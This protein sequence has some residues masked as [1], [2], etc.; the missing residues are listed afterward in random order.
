M[1]LNRIIKYPAGFCRRG[2]IEFD[3][4]ANHWSFGKIKAP[5]GYLIS[6]GL[7]VYA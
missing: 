2:N 4:K 6:C 5:P 1:S 7:S 3:N